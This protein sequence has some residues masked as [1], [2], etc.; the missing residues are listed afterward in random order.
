MTTTIPPTPAAASRPPWSA[1]SSSGSGN[2]A[3]SFFDPALEA[4]AALVS[5]LRAQAVAVSVHHD[6]FNVMIE[7]ATRPPSLLVISSAVWGAEAVRLIEV[8]RER[9]EVPVALAMMR[10]DDPQDFATAIVAGLSPLLE[11]PY[12]L[13]SLLAALRQTAIRPQADARLTVGDLSLDATA[14][15]AR[16]RGHRVELSAKEFAALWLL[17]QRCGRGV[18]PL[19]LSA[20]VWPDRGTTLASTRTLIR[21]LRRRLHEAHVPV[22]IRTVRGI[23]YMLDECGGQDCELSPA[24]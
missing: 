5:E 14:L 20:V 17:G 3:L 15:T 13:D 2:R 12:R 23:G 4:D 10:T 6:A 7:M 22:T 1:D 16:Y 24:G 21:R 11:R 9:F 19:E 8:A 18:T